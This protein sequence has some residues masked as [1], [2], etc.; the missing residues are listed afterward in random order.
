MSR[1]SKEAEKRGVF[2]PS[3]R[4]LERYGIS[5]DEWLQ[6][7]KDQGWKCPICLKENQKWNTDHEHVPAWRHKP[8]EERK[9]YVRGVLCWHCNHKRVHSRMGS[10][11]AQRITEY[12]RQYERRRDDVT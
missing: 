12:I 5:T 4:T 7:L 3:E 1:L 8:P 10:E 2:A 6:L 9:R 11:E